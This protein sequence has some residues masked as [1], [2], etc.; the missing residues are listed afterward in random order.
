MPAAQN[1]ITDKRKNPAKKR[2]KKKVKTKLFNSFEPTCAAFAA[3]VSGAGVL[4]FFTERAVGAGVAK[5]V[6]KK[7][8]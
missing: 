6:K 5:F 2:K 4:T 1:S 3:S 8:N 7:E